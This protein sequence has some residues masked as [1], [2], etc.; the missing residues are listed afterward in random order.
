MRRDDTSSLV[1]TDYAAMKHTPMDL[2]FCLC[3]DNLS[4]H[5]LSSSFRPSRMET[6][7]RCVLATPAVYTLSL[8][9]SLL[10]F[11]VLLR[12]FCLCLVVFTCQNL[13]PQVGRL[14]RQGC[15]SEHQRVLLKPTNWSCSIHHIFDWLCA[16][17][18]IFAATSL[19]LHQDHNVRMLAWVSACLPVLH[20]MFQQHSS[21]LFWLVVCV[22]PLLNIYAHHR[23][24]DT[25]SNVTNK[26]LHITC[27]P[28][29]FTQSTAFTAVDWISCS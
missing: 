3:N 9:L 21:R 6:T 18:S 1:N 23:Q 13:N 5:A 8:L 7:Q 15:Y 11:M 16:T 29:F 17:S 26:C 24:R 22:T 2:I 14:K 20:V 19:H 25:S 28:A 12:C 27:F 4:A 10:L